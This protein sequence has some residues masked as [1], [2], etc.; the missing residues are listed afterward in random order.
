MTKAVKNI[1]ILGSCVSRDVLKQ[2]TAG[3]LTLKDYFARTSFGSA[4][5]SKPISKS[6][7][8]TTTLSSAFQK[9]MVDNDLEKRLPRILENLSYD[10]VFVDL[11]DERFNILEET[12]FAACTAS[13]ELLRTG[14][15][16]KNDFS[17]QTASGSERHQ[18]LWQ[19]GWDAFIDL[20]TAQ[21][22][23]GKLQVNKVFWA[24]R[25]ETGAPLNRGYPPEK[26]S[27]A[28]TY[29]RKLYEHIETTLPAEQIMT[30][31]PDQFIADSTHEWG[32]APFHYTAPYYQAAAQKFIAA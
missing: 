8:D 25:T 18:Q 20:L 16:P 6:K 32:V 29:L 24:E 2:D 12:R 1:V 26:I 7:V 22:N 23:L 17:R 15:S 31:S 13:T 11:I 19:R 5:A 21:N 27:S 9:R 14:I 10:A 30:F 3:V 28:N 4:F